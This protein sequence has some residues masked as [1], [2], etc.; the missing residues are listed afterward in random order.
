MIKVCC[1]LVAITLAALF[2]FYSGAPWQLTALVGFT[3][4]MV[5][6]TI[7]DQIE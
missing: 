2:G 4:G 6:K 3:L 1:S 7:A 5:S